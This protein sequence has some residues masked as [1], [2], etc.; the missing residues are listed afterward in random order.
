MRYVVMNEAHVNPDTK[1]TE[2]KAAKL[3]NLQA[4]PSLPPNHKAY[5]LPRIRCMDCPGK[6]YNA[7]P[8]HTVSN[9]E[10]HLRNR[11]HVTNVAKRTGQ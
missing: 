5:F 11:V 9:F 10:L 6:L 8:E 1:K 4:M 3:D 7:G 2:P